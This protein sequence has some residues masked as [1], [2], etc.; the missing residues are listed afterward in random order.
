MDCF[1]NKSSIKEKIRLRKELNRL[2]SK[3]MANIYLKVV[4]ENTVT[5]RTF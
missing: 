2:L 1:F 3:R 5:W 4:E